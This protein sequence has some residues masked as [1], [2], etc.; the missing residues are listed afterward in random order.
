MF[1]QTPV[2]HAVACYY[3]PTCPLVLK[4]AVEQRACTHYNISKAQLK[5][6]R[7]KI[8]SLIF[9]LSFFVAVHGTCYC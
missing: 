5:R 7:N 1:F 2:F 3:R 9:P 8:V 4:I 6:L